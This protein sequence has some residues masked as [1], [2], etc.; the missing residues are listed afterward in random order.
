MSLKQHCVSI[1]VTHCKKSRCNISMG[2]DDKPVNTQAGADASCGRSETMGFSQSSVSI[3]CLEM[4]MAWGGIRPL[5]TEDT[6]TAFHFAASDFKTQKN[7]CCGEAVRRVS[8]PLCTSDCNRICDDC[9]RDGLACDSQMS[10]K[11]RIVSAAA[12]DG[13]LNT[14]QRASPAVTSSM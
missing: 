13:K 1:S 5:A 11:R 6:W 8:A 2:N 14:L 4:S 12:V 3:R 7:T 9:G 10:S